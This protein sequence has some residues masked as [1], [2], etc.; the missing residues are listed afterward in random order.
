[1]PNGDMGRTMALEELTDMLRQAR[2]R[3]TRPP[4]PCD[5]KLCE[6]HPFQVRVNYTILLAMWI[7]LRQQNRMV[8]ISGLVSSITSGLIVGAVL[9][10]PRIVEVLTAA[11]ASG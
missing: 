4:E 11:A 8:L 5:G 7:L 2:E 10:L 9:A 3:T 1:M 6:D